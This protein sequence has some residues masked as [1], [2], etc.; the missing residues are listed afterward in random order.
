M[1]ARHLIP[2]LLRDNYV[3]FILCNDYHCNFNVMQIVLILFESEASAVPAVRGTIQQN[4]LNEKTG[5]FSTATLTILLEEE[6]Y[7][8]IKTYSPTLALHFSRHGER[9]R[10]H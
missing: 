2:A 6:K 7:D 1:K 10:K 3:L 9:N 8:C 4:K 5:P